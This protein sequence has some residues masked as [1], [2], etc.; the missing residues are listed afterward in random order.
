MKRVIAMHELRTLD[1]DVSSACHIFLLHREI[2][3]LLQ[4]SHSGH[5]ALIGH[6]RIIT[7]KEASSKRGSSGQEG[8][9]QATV[10]GLV[11]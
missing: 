9:Q 5:A 3:L 11:T 6:T 2:H 1:Y 4:L 8:K 7:S 10:G